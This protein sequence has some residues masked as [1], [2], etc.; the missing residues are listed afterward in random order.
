MKDD[1]HF[2]RQMSWY[3]TTQCDSLE[4][5]KNGYGNLGVDKGSTE[6]DICLVSIFLLY[7]GDRSF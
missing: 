2:K 1:E 5:D 4:F 3:D 7:T 6:T